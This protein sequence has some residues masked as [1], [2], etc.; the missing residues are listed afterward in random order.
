MYETI[1]VPTDGSK[2]AIRAA[3]HAHYLM[4]AFDATVHLVSAADIQTAGGMFNAGGVDRQFVERIEAEYEDAIATTE[5]TFEGDAIETSV[6]RGNL[7]M[8]YSNTLPNTISISSRWG[9]TVE[10]G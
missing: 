8:R 1:L 7:L 3:E 2:H 5:E 10:P 9:R 6:L 4:Q